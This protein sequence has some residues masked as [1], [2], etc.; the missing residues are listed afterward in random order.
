MFSLSVLRECFP[1]QFYKFD[2]LTNQVQPSYKH[3]GIVCREFD[4]NSDNE[5]PYFFCSDC[6]L[7]P[8]TGESVHDSREHSC[9]E[10]CL[11]GVWSVHL[12]HEQPHQIRAQQR[13]RCHNSVLCAETGAFFLNTHIAAAICVLHLVAATVDKNYCLPI[14]MFRLLA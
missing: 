7:Q 12:H 3:F 9:E 6:D 5:R 4:K 8:E 10:R 2:R 11:G 13:V 14:E 1:C